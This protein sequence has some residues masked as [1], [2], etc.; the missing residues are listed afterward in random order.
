MVWLG[1]EGASDTEGVGTWSAREA[2]SGL[3]QV[4]GDAV[5]TV[6]DAPGGKKGA[7]RRGW[8]KRVSGAVARYQQWC[9]QSN[10]VE[11][12][13]RDGIQLMLVSWWCVGG[14]GGG[15]GRAAGGWAVEQGNRVAWAGLGTWQRWVGGSGRATDKARVSIRGNKSSVIRVG[16]TLA[17]PGFYHSPPEAGYPCST[18]AVSLRSS[19]LPW[20]PVGRNVKYDP[21]RVSTCARKWTKVDLRIWLQCCCGSSDLGPVQKY[22]FRS[23]YTHTQVPSYVSLG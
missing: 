15:G 23:R 4:R 18:L 8:P 9:A 14:C 11:F 10:P 19:T 1:C 22:R 5:A 2:R 20:R 13:G 21:T 3:R 16:P 17:S 12:G 6:D 7:R